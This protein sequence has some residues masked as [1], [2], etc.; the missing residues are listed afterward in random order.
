MKL[1]SNWCSN[2]SANKPLSLVR[3]NYAGACKMHTHSSGKCHTRIYHQDGSHTIG[4]K[5]HHHFPPPQWLPPPQPTQ[6]Q[7]QAHEAK[8]HKVDTYSTC[9]YKIE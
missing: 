6:T 5:H 2:V 9:E 1:P 8:V 7:T 3:Y 4:N